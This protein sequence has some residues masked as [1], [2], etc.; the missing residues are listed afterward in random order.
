MYMTVEESYIIQKYI[1]KLV[2]DDYN[3]YNVHCTYYIVL[4]M[5]SSNEYNY[6]LRIKEKLQ[7]RYF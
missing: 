6:N 4:I 3:M 7:F 1:A 2:I 5:D